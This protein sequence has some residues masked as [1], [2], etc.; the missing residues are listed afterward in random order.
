MA[1]ALT[2]AP[3]A[4]I[5]ITNTAELE[6]ALLAQADGQTWLIQTGNY[7]LVAD[8]AKVAG[9]QGGWFFPITAN[10]LTIIGQGNPVIYGNDLTPNGPWASQDLIGV[11]G[12]NCSIKGLTLMPTYSDNKTVE[13]VGAINFSISH[14]IFTA[15]T[16]VGS[17]WGTADGGCVYVNGQNMAPAN[18]KI[19]IT[20]NTF[21]LGLVAFDGP[22]AKSIRVEDNLFNGIQD[23][24]YA[25]GATYWGDLSKINDP[26]GDVTLGGNTFNRMG[27]TDPI[28]KARLTQTFSMD[29][30]FTI[31]GAKIKQDQFGQYILFDQATKYANCT[32]AVKVGGTIYTRP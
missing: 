1:P 23:G 30:D 29:M 27:S 14:C 16:H 32:P 11:F 2:A 4:T 6:A 10:N 25:I 13:V 7:G 15:N 20:E 8:A 12:N 18:N 24:A 3:P 28:I 17:Q 19:N 5:T 9:G 31:D 22:A 26:Y 21:N